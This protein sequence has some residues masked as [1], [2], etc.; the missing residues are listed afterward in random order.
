MYLYTDCR[1]L[2]SFFVWLLMRTLTFSHFVFCIYGYCSIYDL[3]YMFKILWT[4]LDIIY[5]SI[6][7]DDRTKTQIFCWK[8]TLPAN[9]FSTRILV[10]CDPH[11]CQN[12]DNNVTRNNFQ[13]MCVSPVCLRLLLRD[14]GRFL[15]KLFLTFVVYLYPLILI[16]MISDN[17]FVHFY[18]II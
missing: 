9:S 15:G 13:S 16:S 4:K 8:V 6:F 5:L 14:Q 17:Y 2:I 18:F 3:K 10:Y 12:V 11:F 7:G 1:F